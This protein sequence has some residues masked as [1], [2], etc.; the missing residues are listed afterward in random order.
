MLGD[1]HPIIIFTSLGLLMSFSC[2]GMICSLHVTHL[3]G[4]ILHKQTY[5]SVLSRG[6]WQMNETLHLRP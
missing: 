1:K 3:D 5:Q 2:E 4:C 6:N